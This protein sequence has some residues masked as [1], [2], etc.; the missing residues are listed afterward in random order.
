MS[1]P[2]T[3]SSM[4]SSGQQ[5]NQQPMMQGNELGSE[6]MG[7]Q[8]E[9]HQALSD[10]SKQLL[11]QDHG[12]EFQKQNFPLDQRSE[13]QITEVLTKTRRKELEAALKKTTSEDQ[14]ILQSKLKRKQTKSSRGSQYRGV[15]K[16]GK[17]WQVQLLGN[18]KKH[19]I[20]SIST[21]IKAARIYDKHAILT[22]GLRAKT[23]F[24]YTKSQIDRILE[25]EL[26]NS[27]IEDIISVDQNEQKTQD[28]DYQL[29]L[30][31]SLQ[32]NDLRQQDVTQSSIIY[33]SNIM[34]EQSQEIYKTSTNQNF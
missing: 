8:N 14:L 25:Q 17:K 3:H 12:S 28:E 10:L 2:L 13:L 9:S 22:H 15:S 19:Y 5:H 6:Q 4:I 24:Q 27:E 7:I 34:G 1:Y 11:N 21:E 31:L 33:E 29:S 20:G 30:T 26:E 18:L 23:N 32:N 16:N